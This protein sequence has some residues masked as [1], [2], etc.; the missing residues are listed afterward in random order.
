M[1]PPDR[2]LRLALA[3]TVALLLAVPTAAAG[4]EGEVR[5]DLTSLE[6]AQVQAEL[7]LT[8]AEADELRE[9]ADRDDDGEVGALEAA[10][11]EE[12][13]GD[14]FEGET[15]AYRLD[16]NA[17]EI[18]SAGV[19]VDG[20]E[21]PTDRETPVALDVEAEASASAGSAPHTFAVRGQLTDV[22]GETA[23]A[24]TVLA[25]D[26]YRIAETDGFAQREDC[27]AHAGAGTENA[28]AT[29]ERADDGCSNGIP[30]PGFAAAV[31]GLV[32]ASL[33]T[34]RGSTT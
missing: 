13:L 27:R 17:Y 11:A 1:R 15:E 25:P 21:G 22:S 7:N 31:A 10:G 33:A 29:F 4:I 16:G 28:T 8:G 9:R 12:V 24:H 20:L 14:R 19:D 30:A 34:R 5:F 32:L 2:R 18:S 26:G 3:C 23:V 6:E